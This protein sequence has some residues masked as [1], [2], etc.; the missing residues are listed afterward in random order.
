VR[1]SVAKSADSESECWLGAKTVRVSACEGRRECER[2]L[3]ECEERRYINISCTDTTEE[4]NP[5]ILKSAQCSVYC[6]V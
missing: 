2:V 1:V 6:V 4:S 5:D 3:V